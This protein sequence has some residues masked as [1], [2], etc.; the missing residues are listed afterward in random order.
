VGLLVLQDRKALKEI[1]ALQ[2][3]PARQGFQGL[4]ELL[5]ILVEPDL[6]ER[7]AIPATLEQPVP[8]EPWETPG[9]PVAREL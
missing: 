1:L 5:A 2:E 7:S 4:L 6:R 3:Q 9:I 8:L